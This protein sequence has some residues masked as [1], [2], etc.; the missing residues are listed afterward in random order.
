M[1]EMNLLTR[2]RAEVPA[3][4]SLEAERRFHA[5]FYSGQDRAPR[6]ARLALPRRSLPLPLIGL[7]AT[8]AAA[9]AVAITVAVP[10]S[11]A[12]H[13]ASAQPPTAPPTVRELAYRAATAA[14]GAKPVSPGQWVYEKST[15][16]TIAPNGGRGKDTTTETW[17]TA[18]GLRSAWYFHGELG[19]HATP[20]EGKDISYAELA[21][22]P[23]SPPALVKYIYGREQQILGPE[24]A[25][26]NWQMTFNQ[27]AGLFNQFV[28]PPKT[29]AALF[30][31][32]P[33]IPGVR[34]A[35][36]TGSIAFTRSYG[37]LDTEKVILS[38]STYTVTGI[39][40]ADPDGG[41]AKQFTFTARTPVS[42]PGVRP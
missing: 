10:H 19:V 16:T 30:Q 6:P 33:S 31:A 41:A 42:G 13:P 5:S 15:V 2:L 17:Q 14:L 21:K 8:L 4:V 37:N 12:G 20:V 23:A 24:P 26:L 34:I 39:V 40:L 38:S 22:L 1:N 27:I 35:K 7:A 29:A 18:D 28:L 3:Q 25:N 36:G 9:V 32:L 11:P